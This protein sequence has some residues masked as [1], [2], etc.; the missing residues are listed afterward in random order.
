MKIIFIWVTLILT[1]PIVNYLIPYRVF[2]FILEIVQYMTNVK[3]YMS[4]KLSDTFPT[5]TKQHIKLIRKNE[6]IQK[7]LEK[8]EIM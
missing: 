5:K 3:T 2:Y 7:I 1:S 6:N 8:C 4:C